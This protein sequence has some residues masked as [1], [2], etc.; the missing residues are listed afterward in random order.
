M[1]KV[2]DV[3]VS[4]G[5]TFNIGNYESVKVEVGL[6]AKRAEDSEDSYINMVSTLQAAAHRQMMRVAEV[7]IDSRRQKSGTFVKPGDKVVGDNVPKSGV[8]K[9][10][11]DRIIKFSGDK[12]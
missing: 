8:S 2:E 12:L 3:Y 1:I 11:L 4:V 6:G 7:E 10:T 9:Q 5:H